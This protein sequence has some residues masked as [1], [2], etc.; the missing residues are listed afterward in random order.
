M[1]TPGR[2]GARLDQAA[3][4]TIEIVADFGIVNVRR[5]TLADFVHDLLADTALD[6]RREFGTC[7][8]AQF[9]QILGEGGKGGRQG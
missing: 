7:R 2:I 9:R 8:F 3:T 4:E 5:L 1:K 6:L